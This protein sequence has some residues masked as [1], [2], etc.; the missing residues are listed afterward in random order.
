MYTIAKLQHPDCMVTKG[1]PLKKAAL[2]WI[3]TELGRGVKI[4]SKSFEG[5]FIL[6]LD[7]FKEMWGGVAK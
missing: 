1:S 2:L 7:N 6:S 4:Q 3:F 5:L